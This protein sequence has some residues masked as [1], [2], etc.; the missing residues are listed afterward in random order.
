MVVYMR[1]EISIQVLLRLL[2]V[3]C[4]F[5]CLAARADPEVTVIKHYNQ[6]YT[7]QLRSYLTEV[8]QLTLDRTA[9]EYGPYD[10]QF[11]SDFLSTNRSKLETEKGV[12]LDVLFSSHW[13]GHF[14]NTQNVIPVEFPVLEGMLGLRSLVVKQDNL[15]QLQGAEGPANFQGLVAGLGSNWVD[16]EILKANQI[17]VVEAQKFDTLFPM[18]AHKRFDYVPLSVLEAQ[19]TLKEQRSGHPDLATSAELYLF[20][21]I[22]FYLYVNARRPE[23]AERLERGL[24]AALA[25]GSIDRLFSRH[26]SYVQDQ[27]QQQPK[28]L[29]LLNN[30]LISAEK[31]RQYQEQFLGKYGKSFVRVA[32]RAAG[33]ESGFPPARE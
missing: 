32:Q 9:E 29:V 3:A 8:L 25:D 6:G 17:Q 19:A 21:P 20:Y 31:N 24:Q 14:V 13:R 16:V 33:P 5:Y 28:H 15:A 22:P 2:T 27:L 1:I 7:P 11:F 4:C 23:L 26:F 18:L 30:P 12:L 10:L